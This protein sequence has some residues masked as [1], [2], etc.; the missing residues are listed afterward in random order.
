MLGAI[1]TCDE[2]PFER[3]DGTIQ[4]ITWDVRPWYASEDVIGGIIMYT[5]DITLSKQK[6]ADR[7][8]IENILERSNQVAKIA[9]WEFDVATGKVLWSKLA[10]E[11]FD[12]PEAYQPDRESVFSFY[13]KGPNLDALLSAIAESARSGKPYDLEVELVT[14]KGI[15]K[16][17]RIIGDSEFEKEVCV[18]RLGIFQDITKTKTIE[19]D[20]IRINK[21]LN[22][23]LNAGHVSIIGT[24]PNGLI[25][26]FS[27]GAERLLQYKASEM[28]GIQSPAII[29]LEAE[30]EKRGIELS[31]NYG[32]EISGFNVFIEIALIEG[33]ESREWSYVRKDGTT[34][35]VQLVATA[36]KD[37]MGKVLGFLGV[38]T[39]ISV[40]K[41]SESEILQLMEI[42]NGQNE[43]LKN[44]AHIVSHNLRSHA[45]NFSMMLDLLTH[46]EPEIADHQY[47]KLIKKASENL[48]ETIANLNEVV[49][50]NNEVEK[51]L[52]PIE[53]KYVVAAA[54]DNVSTLIKEAKITM[55][56]GIE[57]GVKVMGLSAYLD[58]IVLKFITN[59]IKYRS[60][61]RES[62]INI[63][64]TKEDNW[65]VLKIED[66]GIG[67]DLKKHQAKLFGMYKTFHPNPD[68]RGIGLFITKNQIEA[69]G[70]KVEV[71]ST[72]NE[73]TTFKIF[74]KNEKS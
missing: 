67:I 65:V 64:A 38:A 12:M 71:T 4:W 22:A 50:M 55:I 70:G 24:D 17:I 33:F 74:L 42:T 16:W 48:T 37:N 39:D 40:I 51:N 10:N 13:K 56:N 20:V 7:R 31:E 68:A 29:H 36:I 44:F 63:S 30:V 58:S 57:A 8:K 15:H 47:I 34:F 59:G 3:E 9:H 66:N 26:H 53:L 32:R 43:R 61:D 5:A 28:V 27:K 21:E 62:E 14:A 23:I 1:N 19:A 45:G 54:I 25:T 72:V 60:L 11:I 52:V 2:A 35:P 69:L 18:R 6:D 46:E 73:G 49:L 41:K